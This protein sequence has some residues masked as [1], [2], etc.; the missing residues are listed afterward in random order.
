MIFLKFRYVFNVTIIIVF[1][2]MLS[3]LFLLEGAEEIRQTFD[4]EVQEMTVMIDAG[5]GGEDGGAQGPDGVLEKQINLAVSEKLEHIMNL[6]GINTDMTRRSDESLF[7]DER[8]SVRERKIADIKRRVEK[9]QKTPRATLISVHQ[10]SFPEE[11]CKGAQVFFS[12]SNVNSKTLAKNVQT[13][14]KSGIDENNRRTE[15]QNDKTIY[16]LENVNCP[17]I[18]VECG[19]LT[20][21]EEAKLLKKDTYQTKLAMCIAAGYLRYQNEK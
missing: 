4:G 19:F 11:N 18:L 16:I 3:T 13:A 15:K 6:C 9:V 2:F 20:N 10:N 17:A 14:L 7:F 1:A 8:N 12:K 21:Q 5:H